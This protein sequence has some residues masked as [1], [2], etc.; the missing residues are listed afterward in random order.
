MIYRKAKLNDIYKMQE[1]VKPEVEKAIILPR[2]DDEVA[3]NIRS[4]IL[5]VDDEEIKG[6]GA[7]HFHSPLLA[8]IRS[9]VVAENTRGLGVGKNIVNLLTNEAKEYHAK[10]VFTLTFQKIF[11]E[12]LNFTEIP[13]E[14]LPPH[15]IWA[16]C[17]KCKF[18]PKCEEIALIK[19]I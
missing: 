13:K 5:A 2:S 8:E 9:L 16:D 11:F 10:E 12:K 1:L 14:L 15:K 19:K 3:T 18:F 4:Y 6:Y 7:L 17:I